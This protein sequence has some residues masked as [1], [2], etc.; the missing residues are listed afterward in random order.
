MKR[1]TGG[2][3]TLYLALTLGIMMS[4]IFTLI[5]GVR[6]QTIRLETEGVMDIGLHSIFGEYHRQLLE[7]YDLFY[8]DT[9]YGE[10]NPSID[11]VEEHL[12]YYMNENFE[13]ERTGFGSYRDLTAIHCD[14]VLL[15]AY[16]RASDEEGQV[17]K[18]QIVE[19][20]KSKKGLSLVEDAAK[21]LNL[22]QSVNMDAGEINA[23]WDQ[24]HEQ[25]NELLNE[26]KRQLEE[27][28]PEE[29]VEVSIDNPAD[30][31]RGTR[32]QGILQMA[33]PKGKTVSAVEIHPE[34]YFSHREALVGKGQ[35]KNEENLIEAAA[36]RVLLQE[37]LF[38]K[39]GYYGNTLDKGVLAYQIEYLLKGESRDDEN[40]K[41]V[42][43]DILLIRQAA[44]TAYLFSSADKQAEAETLATIISAVL[45]L[46]ELVELIKLTI[47]FA[48]GYAESVRDIHILLDGNKVPVMKDDSSWNTS[49]LQLVNFT[50]YLEDYQRSEEGMDYRDYLEMFLYLNGEEKTLEKFMDICEMDIRL[51][52]GNEYFRMDGCLE[53]V[54]ARASVTSG[55]GH[56]YDITRTFC[57]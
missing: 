34:Y 39:C 29:E 14:N 17:L 24:A 22:I 23:Q 3:I 50:A 42:L 27:E 49:L 35:L 1:Q 4:L 57:Y 15:E 12:Q 20:M 16:V 33:L 6:M 18:R 7:Q 54:R 21:N 28:F 47:L 32:G 40:L 37:Y 48:W 45:L 31:V 52:A 56:S 8:I 13:K 55:Y 51:T 53:A 19:Y 36:G 25:I 5:S 46:P 41:E 30:Y 44:N 43:E 26:R 38:E 2:Y 9:T 11:R 10:G